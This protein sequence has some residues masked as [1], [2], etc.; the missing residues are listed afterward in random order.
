MPPDGALGL[1]AL[2]VVG[3]TLALLLGVIPGIWAGVRG[4]ERSRGHAWIAAVVAI[5]ALVG[6]YLYTVGGPSEELFTRLVI[7]PLSLV[8]AVAVS[9]VLVGAP[10]YTGYFVA[11]RVAR[12]IAGKAGQP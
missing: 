10:M 2:V 12:S 6:L 8:I 4:Y 3:I 7:L 5:V 1:H 11:Y 9:A